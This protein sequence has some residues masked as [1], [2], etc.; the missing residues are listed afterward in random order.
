MCAAW[1]GERG[2][3]Y[4]ATTWCLSRLRNQPSAPAERSRSLAALAALGDR[5]LKATPQQLAL[6]LTGRFRHVHASDIATHLR[7]IDTMSGE[8]TRLTRRSSSS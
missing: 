1:T 6:A 3:A 5:R 8:I 4:P 2:S 7:L